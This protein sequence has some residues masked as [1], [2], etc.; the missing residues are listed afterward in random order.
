MDNNSATR[1]APFP[2]LAQLMYKSLCEIKTDNLLE[3]VEHSR[4]DPFC[5][6]YC[7]MHDMRDMQFSTAII[8]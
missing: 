4:M 6:H 1:P 3:K 2:V 8:I 7:D 5:G